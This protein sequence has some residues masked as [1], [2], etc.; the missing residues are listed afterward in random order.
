MNIQIFGTK[1][2]NDT[3]KAERF[4]KERRIKFQFIDL[5]EKALSKGELQSVKKVVGLENLINKSAKDYTKLNMDKIRSSEMR[6]E[7]L[8]KN[9]SLY[10][11]PIVRNGKD[12]TVG[13]AIETWKTWE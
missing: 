5:K 6:E 8:L 13:Y 9:P 3:K 11:T 12:A 7:I 4:F 1:K 2:C 10:V